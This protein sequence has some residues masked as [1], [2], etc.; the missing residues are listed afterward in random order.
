[1]K[2]SFHISRSLSDVFVTSTTNE[3]MYRN[4]S[5]SHQQSFLVENER[6][7]TVI[8]AHK[9]TPSVTVRESN[10]QSSVPW[11]CHQQVKGRRQYFRFDI[12]KRLGET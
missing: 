8:T 10:R 1:M 7:L 11:E 3:C 6:E 5:S 2:Y 4:V 9:G 12:E